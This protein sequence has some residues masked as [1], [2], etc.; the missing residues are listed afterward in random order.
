MPRLSQETMVLRTCINTAMDSIALCSYYNSTSEPTI[1]HIAKAQESLD[2]H[3]LH[4]SKQITPK[5]CFLQDKMAFS[6]SHRE[7]RQV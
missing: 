7:A 4:V 6:W 2:R 5:P 3:N 1:S